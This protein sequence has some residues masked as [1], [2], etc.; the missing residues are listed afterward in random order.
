[1]HPI[2]NLTGTGHLPANLL[3]TFGRDSA[4]VSFMPVGSAR[5]DTLNAGIWAA[6]SIFPGLA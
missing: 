4:V 1:M 3:N 2:L 5:A 6:L